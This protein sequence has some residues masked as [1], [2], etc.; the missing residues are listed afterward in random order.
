MYKFYMTKANGCLVL[1]RAALD[2]GE[3]DVAIF[4]KNAAT[5]YKQKALNL[6]LR[7]A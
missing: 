7:E 4:Y 1:A 6:S 3:V 5:G 2:K